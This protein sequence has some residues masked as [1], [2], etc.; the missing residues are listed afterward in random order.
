MLIGMAAWLAVSSAGDR[1]DPLNKAEA[2]AY[3]ENGMLYWFELN[4]R[5][6]KVTGKQHLM[7]VIEEV[8]GPPFLEEKHFSIR[9]EET[10]KWYELKVNHDG[11]TRKYSAW[12]S[13]P[14]LLIQE[15]GEK[16]PKV[17]K[18]A[19]KKEIEEYVKEIQREYDKAV[20]H[21]EEKEKTRLRNFFSDLNQIYGF[22]YSAEDGSYQLFVKIDEALLQGE[23]AGSLLM[24][25]KTGNPGNPYEETKYAFNGI[26]D[27]QILE[28]YTMVDGKQTMLKGN[29]HGGAFAFDSSFWMA[30][31]KL[32]FMAVTEAQYKQSYTE[33]QEKAHKPQ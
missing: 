17:Y 8:G 31:N 2:F 13:G 19:E 10:G 3:K 24:M 9:G 16:A 7:K 18:A 15:Q 21:S 22:L 30:E 6:G 14:K 11:K 33:F 27:G 23:V 28:L 26:T 20:Y 1:K 12:F 5:S 29:F 4:S 25:A 32:P